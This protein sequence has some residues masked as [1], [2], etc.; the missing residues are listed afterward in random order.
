[1]TTKSEWKR[2]AAES[3]Q[4][5]EVLRARWP[6]AFPLK[7]HQVRPLANAAPAIV[8]ALG[9]TNAYARGVLSAWLLREAYCR[10]VLQYPVRMNLDGSASEWAVDDEARA[11]ATARL[12]QIAARKAKEAERK[13]ELAAAAQPPA[14]LPKPAAAELAP[15]PI[16]PALPE[17]P[18]PGSEPPPSARKLLTIPGAKEALARRGLGTTE[19]VATI[20]RRAR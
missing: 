1:M 4:Q 20:Q 10:A 12:A 19:V 3:R 18:A 5:I 6:K 13:A 11:L 17:T 9:W 7:A 8:E 14:P 15:P 16:A 2:G